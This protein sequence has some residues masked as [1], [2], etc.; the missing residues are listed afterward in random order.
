MPIEDASERTPDDC[1]SCHR[2]HA[3]ITEV[4]T[5]VVG[6]VLNESHS[7]IYIYIATSYGGGTGT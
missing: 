6:V 2:R 5:A 3:V 4:L 1:A 7:P